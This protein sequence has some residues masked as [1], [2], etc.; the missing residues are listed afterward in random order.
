MITVTSGD[1]LFSESEVL[2]NVRTYLQQHDITELDE[3]F[4]SILSI[5]LNEPPDFIRGA[6][7]VKK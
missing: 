3:R 4:I 6:L 2:N 1:K 5:A 7:R